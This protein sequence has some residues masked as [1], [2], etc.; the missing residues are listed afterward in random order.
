MAA[1]GTRRPPHPTAAAVRAARPPPSLACRRTLARFVGKVQLMMEALQ[2]A[3]M[4]QAAAAGGPSDDAEEAPEQAMETLGSAGLA[5]AWSA[6]LRD[7]P[8]DSPAASQ[9]LR[10]AVLDSPMPDAAPGAT[11]SAALAPPAAL[12]AAWAEA[13]ADVRE[14]LAAVA[15]LVAACGSMGRLQAVLESEEQRDR[16]AAAV[17]DLKLALSGLQAVQGVAPPDVGE[18]VAAVQRQLAALLFT[19]NG[20]SEQLTGQLLEVGCG[21]VRHV[22]AMTGGQW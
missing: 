2:P 22:Q 8:A 10:S 20:R 7:S 16:F 17:L 12:L 15:D 4:Q 3:M 13:A 1:L 5:A 9:R 11:T 6:A 21:G 14:A 18:D 19:S